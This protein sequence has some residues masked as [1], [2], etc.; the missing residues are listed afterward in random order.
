[1]DIIQVDLAD[2][3]QVK[4]FLA[5][6]VR[7]YQDIPQWVPPLP[8]DEHVRLDVKRYPYY[9]HSEAAFFLAYRDRNPV[10]RVAVLDNRLFNNHNHQETAFFYLF[11]CEAD[12]LTADKLF[13][14]AF[15]WARSRGL[16]KIIGPK[17]FTALDGLGML[18]KGFE[19]RPALGVP[20]NPPYYPALIEAQGFEK[21]DEIASGYLSVDVKFPERIHEL[22]ARIKERRGLRIACFRKRAELR[23]GLTHL[24][25]LY[26]SV[27][28]GTDGGTPITDEEIKSLANQ[29][30]WFADPKL[31]KIVM[32]VDE[33]QPGKER[34]VGFLLAYPDISAA[35]QKTGGRLLPL[36][37]LTILKE[38]RS[39]EWINI[40]GMGMID[41]FRGLG[42][43]A[44]LFSEMFK[45]VVETPHYRHAEVVQIGLEN[46]RMQ[47]EMEIFGID[48][49][50]VHR[51]YQKVLT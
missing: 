35:L 25:T 24:K 41:E 3:Q 12:H 17:G 15:S 39:T 49:Y 46:D 36:G 1:M 22:A 45:S 14:R 2:K 38:L 18:I 43:T 19:R 8:W 6:P 42:G 13:E 30:L 51:I 32:K 37:W 31:I 10:G 7:L 20:Y 47:R 44:L 28:A 29:M 33:R 16:N 40:N 5:L 4:D 27:L 21:C 9:Q 26:N 11:E 23:T 48:F 50:K 34:P